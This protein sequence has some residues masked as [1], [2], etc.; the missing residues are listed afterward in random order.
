MI[1]FL[2]W[3]V[4]NYVAIFGIIGAVLTTSNLIAKLTPTPNDNNI[5]ESIRQFFEKV[6]NL[7]LPDR[8]KQ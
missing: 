4:E 5:I 3:V 1:E 6:S 8:Q 7:F 2:D